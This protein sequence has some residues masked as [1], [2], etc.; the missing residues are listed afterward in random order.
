M[1]DVADG[2]DPAR[3]VEGRLQLEAVIDKLATLSNRDRAAVLSGIV[4]DGPMDPKELDR[5]KMRRHRGRQQL[6][7]ATGRVDPRANSPR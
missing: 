6:L 4:D 5:V 2:I 7:K 1:P 3:I